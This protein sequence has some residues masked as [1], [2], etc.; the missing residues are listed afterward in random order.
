MQEVTTRWSSAYQ[1]LKRFL[2]L[3]PIV[4]EVLLNHS[5][6]TM[7]SGSE[8]NTIRVFA[9]VLKPFAAVTEEMSAE[10]STSSKVIPVANLLRKVGFLKF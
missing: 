3:A 6:V 4:A 2:E 7:L 9:A 1:M 10:K 5:E 8:L